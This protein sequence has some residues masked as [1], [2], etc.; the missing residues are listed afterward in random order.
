MNGVSGNNNRDYSEEARQRLEEENFDL[1][2]RLFYIQQSQHPSSSSSSSSSGVVNQSG[3]PRDDLMLL[4]LEERGIELEQ[5]NLLIVK[6][7]RVSPFALNESPSTVYS[8]YCNI[9]ET[10]GH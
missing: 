5:K 1:K 3:Q 10:V 7:K 6:A 4:Q 9:L 2:L 8:M